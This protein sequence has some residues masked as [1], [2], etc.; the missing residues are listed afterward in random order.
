M[1][2]RVPKLKYSKDELTRTW[3]SASMLMDYPDQNLLAHLDLL[4][5]VA[6]TLPAKLGA[7]L[8]ATIDHLRARPLR[9]S[10]SD[11]VDTFDNRRRGC[12]F[13]TYFSNGETRKRG[14]A[15]LR[16]KQVYTRAG[17]TLTDDQLPDHL[18]VVLEFA[19]TIDQQAGLK[20]ILDN[21]AGL[22]L[23]RLHLRE[24]ESPW[25]GALEAV[26]AT[27]PPLKGTDHEAVE[28]LI[29]EGPEEEQVGLNPY[30][31]PDLLPMPG[32]A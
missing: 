11:Y 10:E 16:I 2:P 23:L 18:C 22:E 17:L 7:R 29:A 9:E 6:A 14:L 28:R 20:M 32:G 15:L 3:Q 24:I 1:T 31:M 21:R 27:L 25:T 13:L 12:L 4:S 26:C 19:A 5:Q 30:G 8:Q